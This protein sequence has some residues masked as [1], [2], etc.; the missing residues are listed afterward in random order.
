MLNFPGFHGIQIFSVEILE[1]W[2]FPAFQYSNAPI[3]QYNLRKY[4]NIGMKYWIIGIFHYFLWKYWNMGILEEFNFQGFQHS[5][6]LIFHL[7]ILIFSSIPNTM[8][9]FS[10]IPIF[11]YSNISS[12]T[13]GILKFFRIPVF[14]YFL[15]IPKELLEYWKFAGFQYSSNTIFQYWNFPGL[16]YSFSSIPIF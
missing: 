4:W 14:Q 1:N 16:Q 5:K 8:L 11:Q 13:I 9:E 10:R 7:E 6:I 2:D 15:R 3:F 12:G